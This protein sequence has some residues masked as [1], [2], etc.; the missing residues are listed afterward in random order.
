MP[1][2][3]ETFFAPDRKSWRAW[4][5][6]HHRSAKSI[7]LVQYKKAHVKRTGE[8]CVSYDAA[9]EEALCFG[10]I[11][12]TLKRIDERQHVIRFTPRRPGS[13]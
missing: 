1:E 9:V 13:I 7:W 10:W 5:R 8:A 11:D 4:L 2:I 12:G 3:S 6:K